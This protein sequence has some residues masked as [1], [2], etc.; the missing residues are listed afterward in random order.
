VLSGCVCTELAVKNSY[1]EQITVTSGH[2]GQSYTIN[3]G[4]TAT[5]P[6]TL[7]PV[8]VE[9]KSGK[10][11]EYRNVSSLDGANKSHFVFW[12]KIVKSFEIKEPEG[13]NQGMHGIR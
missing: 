2:T 11:W 3:T 1:P 4:K 6:H 10:K 5:V 8:M 9:T 12:H 13:P 7:G